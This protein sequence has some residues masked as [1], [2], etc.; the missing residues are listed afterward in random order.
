MTLSVD[1]IVDAII[2]LAE[3]TQTH[4]DRYARWYGAMMEVRMALF[5]RDVA[6]GENDKQCYLKDTRRNETGRV[7]NADEDACDSVS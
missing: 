6:L 7:Y 4:P 1:S 3:R 2:S 5:A